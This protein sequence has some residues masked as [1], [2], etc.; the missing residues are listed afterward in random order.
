MARLLLLLVEVAAVAAAGAALVVDEAWT[1]P[2][3]VAT[4]AKTAKNR[5]VLVGNPMVTKEEG[6]DRARRRR[7][8]YPLLA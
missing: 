4:T 1:V 6:K 2:G 8:K 5:D 7:F 3:P